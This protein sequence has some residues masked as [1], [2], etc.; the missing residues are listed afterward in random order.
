MRS[1]NSNLKLAKTGRADGF[2][3]KFLERSNRH[4]VFKCTTYIFL[5]IFKFYARD[6][7][8]CRSHL[9]SNPFGRLR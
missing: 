9:Q 4:T 2:F 3:K 6:Q 7:H 8:T 5:K 1:E